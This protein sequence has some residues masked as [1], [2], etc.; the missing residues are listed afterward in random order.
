MPLLLAGLFLTLPLRAPACH[1]DPGLMSQPPESRLPALVSC[2]DEGHPQAWL[3]LAD[4]YLHGAGVARD[5]ATAAE[6]YLLAAQ[7]GIPRAQLQYGLMLLDGEGVTQDS[8]EALEWIFRA[9]AQGYAP[10]ARV[11]EYLMAHPEPLDC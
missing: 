4:H 8:N 1:L 3:I 9:Q 10:A 7:A 11:F 2:A 5:P 6:Y